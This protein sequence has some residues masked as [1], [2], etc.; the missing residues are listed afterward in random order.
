[1]VVVIS[2]DAFIP[3]TTEQGTNAINLVCDLQSCK[4]WFHLFVLCCLLSLAQFVPWLP[5][6]HALLLD[7]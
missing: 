6:A 7:N 5:L 4:E 3:R 1:M 2:G